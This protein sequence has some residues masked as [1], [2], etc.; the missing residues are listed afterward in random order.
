MAQAIERL[1][2]VAARSSWVMSEVEK[3]VSARGDEEDGFDGESEHCGDSGVFSG[4]GL[5][6]KDGTF[7]SIGSELGVSGTGTVEGVED[8]SG[9]S[10]NSVGGYGLNSVGSII[11]L[12]GEDGVFGL[13]GVHDPFTRNI[14]IARCNVIIARDDDTGADTTRVCCG[15]DDTRAANQETLLTIDEVQPWTKLQI[16]PLLSTKLEARLILFL[17]FHRRAPAIEKLDSI[18][19]R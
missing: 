17:L 16:P 2:M 11:N 1:R 8:V 5:L 18:Y 19:S 7:A 3:R 12:V 4:F 14:M 15:T 13:G 6:G 10:L 9:Y